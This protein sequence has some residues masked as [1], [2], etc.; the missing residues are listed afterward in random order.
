MR[1]FLAVGILCAI[2]Q[3]LVAFP[4]DD[5]AIKAAVEADDRTP[6]LLV[7][8]DDDEN[9]PTTLDVIE[10][11]SGSKLGDENNGTDKNRPRRA[12]L[13]AKAALLKLGLLKAG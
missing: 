10:L 11:E 4:S 13:L 5:S 8:A 6:V 2:V 1:K 3:V 9:K 12:L 7:N